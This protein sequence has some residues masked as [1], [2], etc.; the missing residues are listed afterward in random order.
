MKLLVVTQAMDGRDQALGFFVR[1]IAELAKHCEQVTVICLK[2]GG[3]GELPENVKVLSLGKEE[4][5]SRIKYVSRLFRYAWRERGSYDAVFVHMN[6][7]Y[8]LLAGW[9]WKL[10]NKRIYMWRNHYAGSW[11]TDLAAA[12][13]TK[14]FCTSKRSYTAK[15]G[16]TVFMPVGV[17]TDRFHPDPAVARLPRSILFLARIAPSK[18]PDMLLDALGALWNDGIAF[19]ADIVGS[20]LPADEQYYE[21]LKAK[22]KELG[23]AERVQ[24]HGAVSHAEAPQLYQAHQVFVNVSPSGMFDKTIFEAAACGCLTLASSADWTAIAPAEFAAGDTADSL[25]KALVPLLELDG[26]AAAKA[27]GP[28][29]TIINMHSLE[30]LARRLMKE[31]KQD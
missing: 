13:C 28:L 9:F 21:S 22:A 8:I 26:A 1:W 10:M 18:R 11:L 20:P 19:T 12:F 29:Q 15:F 25:Q 6:Q 31:M 27:T 14:V 4:G 17:D 30:S 24:F 5:R 3:H 23:I 16:K 2:E 7:E